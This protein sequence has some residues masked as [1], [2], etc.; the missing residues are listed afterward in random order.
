MKAIILTV[1][2]PTARASTKVVATSDFHRSECTWEYSLQE[3]ANIALAAQHHIDDLNMQPHARAHKLV[4]VGVAANPLKSK[5][6]VALV[7]QRSR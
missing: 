7:D 4:L 2:A 3:L 5:E 1:K 6:Y